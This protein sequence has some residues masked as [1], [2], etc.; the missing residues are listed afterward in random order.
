M[1]HPVATAHRRSE[2]TGMFRA[3]LHIHSKFCR[4]C[5]GI[6]DLSRL[7]RW[8]R[9]KG[10]TEA[11]PGEITHPAWAEELSGSLVPA[12][13]GLLRLRPEMADRLRR[14]AP[15]SCNCRVRF[16]L[17]AG[18]STSYRGGD[19]TRKV[20]RLIYAPTFDAADP[21]HRRAGQDRQP[22]LRW[23]PHSRA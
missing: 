9:R 4:A 1:A 15:R 5:G 18:I 12:E 19:R 14:T 21:H 10:I 11:G 8:G 2:H 13:P 22:G 17:S 3:D 16:V 7:A 6:R 23:P 20:H